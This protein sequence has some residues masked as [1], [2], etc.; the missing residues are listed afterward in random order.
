M[1]LT[2]FDTLEHQSSSVFPTSAAVTRMIPQMLQQ[3]HVVNPVV[4]SLLQRFDV[5]CC[6]APSVHSLC[7][8]VC[9]VSFEKQRFPLCF[10]SGSPVSLIKASA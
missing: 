6:F 4:P 7:L 1:T 3:L 10:L 8:L 9:L 2:V 5:C